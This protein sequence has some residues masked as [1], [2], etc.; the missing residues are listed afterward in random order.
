MQ[1]LSKFGT[2]YGDVVVVP[3]PTFVDT[4]LPP[5]PPGVDFDVLVKALERHKGPSTQ[6]VTKSGRLWGYSQGPP[7]HL[8]RRRAFAPLKRC[9][10][11]LAREISDVKR[12]CLFVGE[13]RA[14]ER[15]S[16]YPDV[17]LQ[18]CEPCAASRFD[19]W[20]SLAVVG[21][22]GT[23]TT[24]CNVEQAGVPLSMITTLAHTFF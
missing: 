7:S 17:F 10:D 23:E 11:R 14:S 20:H 8:K 22:F 4:V 9:A 1:P 18:I 2:F 19:K 21:S 15:C 5:M 13:S 16:D 24:P 12:T 3:I 6:L